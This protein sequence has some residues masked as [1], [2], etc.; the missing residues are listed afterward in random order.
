MRTTPAERS[1]RLKLAEPLGN[2]VRKLVAIVTFRTFQRWQVDAKKTTRQREKRKRG[3][4]HSSLDSEVTGLGEMPAPESVDEKHGVVCESWP[5]G[6][7]RHCR[8]A[9]A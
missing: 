4:P 8:R 7:L 5:G 9:A 2:A 6:V 3:R 1:R